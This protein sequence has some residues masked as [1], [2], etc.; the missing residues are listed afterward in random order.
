M[1]TIKALID[2]ILLGQGTCAME[3]IDCT[4]NESHYKF[5]KLL[6]DCEEN[7]IQDLDSFFVCIGGGGLSVSTIKLI[8]NMLNVSMMVVIVWM[9]FSPGQQNVWMQAI[10]S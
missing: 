1:V 4:L 10:H 9:L 2:S 5:L 3:L 6:T 7:G 8:E